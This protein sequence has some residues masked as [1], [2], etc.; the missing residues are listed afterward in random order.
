MST[1]VLAALRRGDP[2]VE[3]GFLCEAAHAPILAGHEDLARL[4][5]LDSQ[6]RGRDAAARAAQADRAAVPAAG[7]TLATIVELR[8]ARYD[9]AV[10]LFFN[11][12]SAWLLRL[13]GIP[14]RIGGA[15]SASRRRL[16]THQA[17]APKPAERPGLFRRAGGGLGEHLSRLAPL[18]HE[19]GRSFLE[20][21][22]AEL[23]PG[24]LAPRVVRPRPDDA[25]LA[26]LERLGAGPG[27]FT[28]LAPAAT[29]PTKEWAPDSWRDLIAR[30][31]AAGRTPVVLSPPGDPGCYADIAAEVPVGRGGMLPPL[32]L[33][34][35]LQMVGAARAMVS[36]DGGVMHA[37]VAMGVPTIGL[38]G[39]TDPALWFPYEDIGPFRVMATR[40][41]CHPCDR[42]EC[43]AFVCPPDLSPGDV[44]DALLALDAWPEGSR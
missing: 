44:A 24:D 3:L 40:P 30:L 32:S 41:S 37:G 15:R 6:R 36:V 17:P 7:G 14:A 22:E 26:A 28:L 1:I 42:H 9:L 29:W 12:R 27:A 43:D 5:A 2:D 10:D 4:H 34:A 8:R 33:P 19:D 23:A 20:W 21:L 13:A 16:Y 39:P 18:R 11:P 35:V 25:V 38:F 31:L